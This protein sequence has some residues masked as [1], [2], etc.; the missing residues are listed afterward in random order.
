MARIV[1]IED[2]ED[3]RS[4]LAETIVR[5]GHEVFPE[6]DGEAGLQRVRETI[7]NVV[8]TDIIMPTK[9]GVET[10]IE[11]RRAFPNVAVIAMSGGGRA[12]GEDYLTVARKFGARYTLAKPFTDQELKE[13]LESVLGSRAAA[14]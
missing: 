2:D 10:I 7:P 14:A 4:V 9:E 3:L 6:A 5:M 12:T 1:L 13:A 11:L 8:V